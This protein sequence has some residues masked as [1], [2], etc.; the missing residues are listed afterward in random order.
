[1]R[2]D[3]LDSTIRD[4]TRNDWLAKELR[5]ENYHGCMD[6]GGAHAEN[7]ANNRG[8]AAKNAMREGYRECAAHE[9]QHFRMGTREN[10]TS[11]FKIIGFVLAMVLFINIIVTWLLSIL[12]V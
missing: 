8:W 2:K 4:D 12:W 1:M 11:P 3:G 6:H 9:K 5:N 10:P 7:R